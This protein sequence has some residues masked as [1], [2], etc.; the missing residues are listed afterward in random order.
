MKRPGTGSKWPARIGA[1][2]LLLLLAGVVLAVVIWVGMMSLNRKAVDTRQALDDTYPSQETFT[3]SPE[4][5][6]PPERME[7]FLAVRQALLPY[8]E[9][10]AAHRAVFRRME[11]YEEAEEDPETG[12][13]LRS[14]GDV[15]STL[16]RV[17]RD[18]GR[19]AIA[20]NQ[21]LLE[22]EMGLGEYTWIYVITYFSWFGNRPVDF[23]AQNEPSAKVFHGRVLGEVKSMIERHVADLESSAAAESPRLR[24]GLVSWQAELD[25]MERDENRTPFQDGLPPALEASLEPFREALERVDCPAPAELEIMQTVD[26]GIWYDHR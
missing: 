7:R 4:G 15:T 8:C 16:W 23:V 25:A 1:G 2:C 5:G 13:F 18:V 9:T 14:V 11:G 10:F 17:G 6:I 21:A 3:P 22:N 20:R 26:T 19:Y 24:D 12:E